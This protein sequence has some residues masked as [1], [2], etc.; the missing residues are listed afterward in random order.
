MLRGL[1]QSEKVTCQ[2]KNTKEQQ[3]KKKK[4]KKDAM[5]IN[6]MHNKLTSVQCSHGWT[7]KKKKKNYYIADFYSTKRYFLN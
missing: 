5:L 2:E 7:G 1:S 6:S 3:D 4:E